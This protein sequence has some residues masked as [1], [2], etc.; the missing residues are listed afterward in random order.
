MDLLPLFPARD[1]FPLLT[2]RNLVRENGR[3]RMD[4]NCNVLFTRRHAFARRKRGDSAS[5]QYNTGTLVA[6]R[7]Q[8][9]HPARDMRTAS[10]SRHC[11]AAVAQILPGSSCQRLGTA[12]TKTPTTSRNHGFSSIETLSSRARWLSYFTYLL[13]NSILTGH[14]SEQHGSDNGTCQ[15]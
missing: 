8:N 6:R 9:L 4:L 12:A 7:L 14:G 13:S 5:R 10:N 11:G 1:H 2:Q 3:R 15:G